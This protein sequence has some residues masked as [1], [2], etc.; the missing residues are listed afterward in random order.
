M[1]SQHL[2]PVLAAMHKGRET[3]PWLADNVAYNDWLGR[4][5]RRDRFFGEL[6]RVFNSFEQVRGKFL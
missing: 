5:D 3:L 4:L 2:I 6:E 1:G